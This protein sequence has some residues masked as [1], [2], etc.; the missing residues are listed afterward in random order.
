MSE[1]MS[2]LRRRL[3]LMGAW[4]A[5][6]WERSVRVWWPALAFPALYAILALFGLWGALGDPWRAI[7]FAATLA[8]GAGFAFA[9]LKSHP[10]PGAT[11]ARR[12][13]EEDSEIAG[14]PFEAL[15]DAPSSPDPAS[16][17][18]WRAHQARMRRALRQ[19]RAR[20]PRAALAALDTFALRGA[21]VILAII[22]FAFARGE[23]G[24]RLADAFQL[25][26]MLP[27]ASGA[28]VE[29][30]IDPPAYTGRAPVF[31][32]ALADPDRIQAPAGS[33]FVARVAGANRAPRLT[34]D[35][36]ESRRIAFEADGAGAYAVTAPLDR[37]ATIRVDGASRAGWR[38]RVVAD[39]PPEAV[40]VG[41][42]EPGNREALS[43][44]YAAR[45]DY[46]VLAVELEIALMQDGEAVTPER[47]PLDIAPAREINDD[48]E[49]I[50]LTEHRWAGLPVRLR[51]IVRDALDQEGVSQPVF[52]DLPER[53]FTDPFARAI[54]QQ[55]SDLMQVTAS[56]ELPPLAGP[57]TAE[58]AAARPA[59][60]MERP[61][62]RLARAPEDVRRVREALELLTAAPDLFAEDFILQMGLSYASDRI[63]QAR[64]RADYA[65][66]EDVLWDAAL[67]AESG[68]L[69]DAER[70][71]R[72]AQRAL[73]SALARGADEEEI[74]RLMEEY[75]EAVGRYM[76]A[77]RQEAIEQGRIAEGGGMEG[78]ESADIEDF[79]NALE[80][81][82]ETG[83]SGDAR[84]LLQ[85][86]AEL[87]ENMEMSLTMGGQ[88]SGGEP[89]EADGELR[90]QLEELGDLMGRQRE[91]MD[92]TL[93]MA[94]GRE[95]RESSPES[96]GEEDGGAED[97]S[98]EGEQSGA[99]NGGQPGESG[100]GADGGEGSQSDGS[101]LDWSDLAEGPGASD[102]DGPRQPGDGEEE[103]ENG[104]GGPGDELE[105]GD[106]AGRQARLAERLNELAEEG[107]EDAAGAIA[108]AE[109]A[110]RRAQESL[111]RGDNRGALDA[112]S[113][114]LEALREAAEGIARQA[115]QSDGR[116]QAGA[117][118]EGGPRPGSSDAVA[119]DPFGRRSGGRSID[120]GI[121]V[122]VPDE[123]DRE[124][125]REILEELRRRA[126]D[127]ERLE[128]ELD[129]I[130]RLLDRF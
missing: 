103:G 41:T 5:L 72:A 96:G 29:A 26:V 122:D 45:D 15:S 17:A 106:L 129:Y 50:D 66:V 8:A 31:L 89:M 109:E 30:W 7:A 126:G 18:L 34:I 52:I 37:S 75:R 47:R 14:R 24:L 35:D 36:G 9:G 100:E 59:F 27:S 16:R 104:A 114:A 118:G 20:R 70:A 21:V 83:A 105:D 97:G 62:A 58:E 107:D 84:R 130:R 101:G 79:L 49:V 51:L 4:A 48:S 74:M 71:M 99:P 64:S 2:L 85:A 127:P 43:F 112:Q 119:R 1:L 124:R 125:A 55:R 10:W 76:E 46:G 32:H 108:D 44:A 13:V 42:P 115:M 12:R 57:F 77:L 98:Q 73:A 93:D 67:R 23:A 38:V 91:L 22:G 68:D 102:E 33:Q 63:A 39:E 65:G 117:S 53:L 60:R 110:M 28:P 56:Y 80:D 113:E 90:E 54:A 123:I 82:A 116:R 92:Q 121:G 3:A 61:G 19:V 6:L 86:M 69:A 95:P 111:E 94:E 128:D 25:R 11:A 88:G 81:L 40:F 120:D 87:L 78:L